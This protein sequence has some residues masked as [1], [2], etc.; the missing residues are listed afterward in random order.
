ME[1]ADAEAEARRGLEAPGRRVHA[2]GR[3]RERVAG[4]EEQGAPV[5]A[6]L[7]GGAGW[8]GQD[9]VPSGGGELDLVDW[10]GL[11]VGGGGR[12]SRML[13]SEGWAMM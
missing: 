8:A 9:V 5:L 1:V 7:V 11:G 3:G 2:D 10:G 12:Y 13:D 6:A 4:W